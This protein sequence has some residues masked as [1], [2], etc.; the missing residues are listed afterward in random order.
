MC[1]RVLHECV[2]VGRLGRALSLVRSSVGGERRMCKL[3]RPA[4]PVVQES[5]S[6]QNQVPVDAPSDHAYSFQFNK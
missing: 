6:Q 3:T 1:V 2:A 4:L 5:G